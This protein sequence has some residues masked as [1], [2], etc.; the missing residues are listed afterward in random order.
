MEVL[1]ASVLGDESL[2][3]YFCKQSTVSSPWSTYLTDAAQE[4]GGLLINDPVFGPYWTRHKGELS[5]FPCDP[6]ELCDCDG[7]HCARTHPTIG[8]A[9]GAVTTAK[10]LRIPPIVV[11]PPT[12]TPSKVDADN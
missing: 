12:P 4:G 3:E 11:V 2:E 6:E 9:A 8:H 5:V 10:C 1:L 7:H